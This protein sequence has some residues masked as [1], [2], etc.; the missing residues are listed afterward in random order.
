MISRH[1]VVRGYHDLFNNLVVFDFS[2]DKR[3]LPEDWY[4]YLGKAVTALHEKFGDHVIVQTR[5][6]SIAAYDTSDRPGAFDTI[7]EAFKKQGMSLD[8]EIVS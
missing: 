8:T 1:V 6:A 5:H 7:V 4:D 3:P 2:G